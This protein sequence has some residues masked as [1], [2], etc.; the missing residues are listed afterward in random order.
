MVSPERWLTPV[1]DACYALRKIGCCNH[2]IGICDW[3]HRA[4]SSPVGHHLKAIM[5]G[6]TLHA[7]ASC[8]PLTYKV[9]GK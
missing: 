3:Q 9:V 1:I 6:A 8:L 5:S 2:A 4:G 7:H